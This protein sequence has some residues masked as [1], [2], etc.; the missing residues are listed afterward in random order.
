MKN[1]FGVFLALIIAVSSISVSEASSRD[2]RK[3]AVIGAIIGGAIVYGIT[4]NNKRKHYRKQKHYDQP[5]IIYHN[6]YRSNHNHGYYHR[7]HRYGH[8]HYHKY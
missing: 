3:A 7:H 5:R 6:R 4:K 2:K 1:I 8:K